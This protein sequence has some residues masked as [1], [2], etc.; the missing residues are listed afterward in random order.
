LL[1]SLAVPLRRLDRF[2]EAVA[3][4]RRALDIVRRHFGDSHPEVGRT[5]SL[6]GEMLSQ[7]GWFAEAY[8]EFDASLAN[9][10]AALGPDALDV[11]AVEHGYANALYRQSLT[12]AAIERYRRAVAIY[13]HHDPQLGW[14]ARSS[15]A[16]A[17][18][19]GGSFDEAEA[20]L[21][22][23]LDE[24]IAAVGE[25]HPDIASTRR[26]LGQLEA[27]RGRPD[28][29]LAHFHAARALYTQIYGHEHSTVAFLLALES[30]VELKRGE[31]RRAV[32]LHE[33]SLRIKRVTLPPGHIDLN[34]SLYFLAYLHLGLGEAER[35][36]PYTEEIVADSEAKGVILDIELV[37]WMHGS[38]LYDSGVDRERGLD[39]VLDARQVIQPFAWGSADLTQQVAEMDAWLARRKKKPR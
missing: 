3:A 39:L 20:T 15:L 18:L 22:A 12:D 5:R 29:A 8:A 14:R 11:A 17:L 30:E 16:S 27:L 26:V 37:R 33:E 25:L 13:Q 36:L 4:Y 6:L 28:D 38:A 9:L 31:P 35:A 1:Q 34:Q 32:E 21:T 10:T 19:D 24:R 7:I 2:D 23:L